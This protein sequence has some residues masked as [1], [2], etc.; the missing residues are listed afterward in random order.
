M[1]CFV[2]SLWWRSE[3]K[4]LQKKEMDMKLKYDGQSVALL[5][6]GQ[7][8]GQQRCECRFSFSSRKL[9]S[10]L[11]EKREIKCNSSNSFLSKLLFRCPGQTENDEHLT[12]CRTE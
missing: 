3:E 4:S 12:S 10:R 1:Y 11:N 5:P 8:R 6:A 2:L 7:I 9:L